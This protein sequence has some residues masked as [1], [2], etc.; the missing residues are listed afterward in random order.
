MKLIEIAS[1]DPDVVD[2]DLIIHRSVWLDMWNTNHHSVDE[3]LLVDHIMNFFD[4]DPMR[5]V[6]ENTILSTGWNL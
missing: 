2:D 6:R 5:E 1:P 3:D 4:Q